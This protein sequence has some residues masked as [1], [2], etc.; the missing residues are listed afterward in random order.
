[1]DLDPRL[2]VAGF[3]RVCHYRAVSELFDYHENGKDDSGA[4]AILFLIRWRPA[5]HRIYILVDEC[6]EESS[7]LVPTSRVSNRPP[8][9]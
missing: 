4:S 7:P 8:A 9:G 1:V 2:C 6:H 5:P 3:H